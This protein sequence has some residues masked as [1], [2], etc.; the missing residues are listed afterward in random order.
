MNKIAPFATVIEQLREDLADPELVCHRLGLLD[1]ARRQRDGY[2]VLCP[3]HKERTPSCSVRRLNAMLLF[4]CF[5]CGAHGDVFGLIAAVDDLDPRRDF[6]AII[7]RAAVISGRDVRPSRDGGAPFR[8]GPHSVRAAGPS[9]PP[10]AEV[11]DVWSRASAVSDAPD[12]APWFRARALSSG[13]VTDFD[14]C[15]RLPAG[16]LPSWAR[17]RNQ[18]WSSAGYVMVFPTFDAWGRLRSLRAGRLDDGSP[19]R[20]APRNYTTVGLVMADPV[21]MNL[22]R[23]R[24]EGTWWQKPCLRIVVTEGEPD[25]LTWASAAS[26]ADEDAPA[27]FGLVSG[28]WTPE[29]GAA[30]PAGSKVIIRTHVDIAGQRYADQVAATLGTGIEIKRLERAA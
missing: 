1:G 29:M 9:Y 8:R 22:L 2:L 25:F 23:R 28:S 19:K 5:G 12:V 6:P 20:V 13:A 18:P 4:R 21:A 16:H 10:Q 14:L 26:D 11:Q 30:I 27:V 3:A 17:I 7:A 24:G 15:R